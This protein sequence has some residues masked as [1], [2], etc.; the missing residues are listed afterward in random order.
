[1]KGAVD[2]Q[3]EAQA[4]Y[5][6]F[7]APWG[8]QQET[9]DDQ[10][11]HN[12]ALASLSQ[13]ARVQHFLQSFLHRFPEQASAA[14]GLPA[15]PTVFPGAVAHTTSRTASRILGRDQRIPLLAQLPE[16]WAEITGSS[17]SPILPYLSPF[18]WIQHT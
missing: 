4:L 11:P 18:C 17:S 14:R 2:S 16:N 13:G 6:D 3:A 7:D 1:M 9:E 10:A 15:L 12:P 8:D 5:K